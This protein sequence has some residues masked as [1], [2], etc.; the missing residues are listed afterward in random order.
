[1]SKNVI[2]IIEDEVSILDGLEEL[3]ELEDY[4]VMRASNGKQAF[5]VLNSAQKPPNLILL[6]LMMPVMDGL[7]FRKAQL[8]EEK[9]SKIPTILMSADGSIE[10][11]KLDVSFSGIIKKPLDIDQ[12]LKK[13]SELAMQ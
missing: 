11:K 10:K 13:L 1:M 6:D 3:L 8:N 5:E 4:S 7:Q 12:L 2:L 9:Y